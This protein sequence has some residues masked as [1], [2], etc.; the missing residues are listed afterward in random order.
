MNC[1]ANSQADYG[2]N[3]SRHTL[4]STSRRW[5]AQTSEPGNDPVSLPDLGDCKAGEVNPIFHGGYR[6][7]DS[8]KSDEKCKKLSRLPG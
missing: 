6:R 4:T 1:G 2:L 7:G 8:K 3:A 5:N